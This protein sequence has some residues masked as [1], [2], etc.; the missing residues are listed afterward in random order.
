MNTILFDNLLSDSECDSLIN[1]S[2]FTPALIDNEISNYIDTQYRKCQLSVIDTKS[3]QWL[4]D[5]LFPA[6][7]DINNNYFKYIISGITELQVIKYDTG[8]FYKKHIDTYTDELNYQRKLTFI[9]QLSNQFDYEEGDLIIHASD[10]GETT[11]RE[12]GSMIVFPSYTLH[13]VTP[14]LSGTRYSLIGWCFGP[15][16]K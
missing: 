14:I 12:K 7:K 4:I 16:F 2:H 5:K 13:E 9:I 3:N 11:T 15:E 8:S 10:I 1:Q 6:L